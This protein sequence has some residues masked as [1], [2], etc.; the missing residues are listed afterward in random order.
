MKI[1]V[2]VFNLH[3]ILFSLAC[4]FFI[5]LFFAPFENTFCYFLFFFKDYFSTHQPRHFCNG[6]IKECLK[7]IFFINLFFVLLVFYLF[8]YYFIWFTSLL[9]YFRDFF[10][11]V[12][13]QTLSTCSESHSSCKIENMSNMILLNNIY[14]LF[15]CY[16]LF[17]FILLF[18]VSWTESILFW[19]ST[20]YF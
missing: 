17:I 7:I 8:S 12:T 2:I 13:K 3:K 18:Q 14:I 5:L 4:N 16:I 1:C 11:P 19:G 15:T 6:W 9:K 10:V 20:N